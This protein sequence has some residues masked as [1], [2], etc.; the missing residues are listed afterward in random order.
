MAIYELSP[1][2]IDQQV[3]FLYC[4]DLDAVDDFYRDVLGLP[5]VLDQGACRIYRTGR[6]SFVGFC[7]STEN[8]GSQ[9]ATGVILTL[10]VGDRA[11]VDRWHDYLQHRGANGSIERPPVLNTRFNIYHLFLRDPA[12]YLVEIQAFLDTAWPRPDPIGGQQ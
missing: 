3:T 7:R 10:V 9:P 5:L 8:M 2:A 1:P 4:G 12:G 11:E 6:D